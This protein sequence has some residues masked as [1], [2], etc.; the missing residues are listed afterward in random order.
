MLVS[1]LA[2]ANGFCHERDEEMKHV[3][4]VTKK[5][6]PAHAYVWDWF[7][8]ITNPKW[9]FTPGLIET[10]GKPWYVNALWASPDSIDPT[11]VNDVGLF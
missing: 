2:L 4:T 9:G 11:D 10:G 7:I 6:G 5:T 1:G 8:N 3:N